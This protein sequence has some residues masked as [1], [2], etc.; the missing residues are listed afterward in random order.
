MINTIIKKDVEDIV[1]RLEYKAFLYAWTHG[2]N[3]MWKD[4]IAQASAYQ[5][6]IKQQIDKNNASMWTKLKSWWSDKF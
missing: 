3:K 2:R 1:E 4:H 5:A 6:E